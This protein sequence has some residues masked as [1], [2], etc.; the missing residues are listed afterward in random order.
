[1]TNVDFNGATFYL[2]DTGDEVYTSRGTHL[3]TL[4]STAKSKYFGADHIK[5]LFPGVEIE[6]GAT[7]LPWLADYVDT[8][9][10]VTIWNEHKDYIRHGANTSSGYR[11][12]DMLIINPDGTLHVD[13][14]VIWDYKAEEQFIHNWAG[15]K[16][17]A[18]SDGSPSWF[19]AK[20]VSHD[21]ISSIKIIEA[22]D[23]PITI[24]N[25]FFERKVCRTVAATGYE[26][27]Y[28]AYGRGIAIKRCNSTIKNLTHHNLDEPEFHAIS[29][30]AG[31][32]GTAT[33]K[34]YYG[35]NTS[36]G[37]NGYYT[38][39]KGSRYFIDQSYP[40]GGFL[41]FS[42]TYNSRA[43]DCN[44]SGRT[45]Y[46]EAKTTSSTPIPMGSYDL[47]ISGSTHVYI[48]N[49]QQLNNINDTH[50]WGIMNSNRAKNL[51]F[52]NSSLSRFDA[53][54]GFWNGTFINTTFGRYINVIG[55]GYLKIDG[56]TR[57]VG[58][59]FISLR[60][61]YGATFNGTIEIKDCTMRGLKEFRRTMNAKP[62]YESGE[63]YIINSGYSTTYD[64]A[65][66]TND[67]NSFPY[68][69]WNFGY[70]CYMPQHVIIDNFKVAG[71]PSI[72]GSYGSY[73]GINGYYFGKQKEPSASLYVFDDMGDAAF[74]K[75]SS[76]VQSDDY[77]YSC[78]LNGTTYSGTQ[79]VLLPNGTYRDMTASDVYYNQYQLTKRIDFKNM[80]KTIPICKNSGLYM[81]SNIPVYNNASYV[82]TFDFVTGE[83]K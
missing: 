16:F 38:D 83:L 28:H 12:Q 25:G 5:Q 23:E 68:L 35:V 52:I 44:L 42:E 61:D 4:T 74:V 56:C 73:T 63:L 33:W 77:T 10:F 36:K 19:G 15:T 60:G 81:Y 14:P 54:E 32:A 37:D 18:N 6:K 26:N 2:D 53:H 72:T 49:V 22:D 30:S 1:M 55:G 41:A 82:P 24:E 9:S 39:S 43:V 8:V 62:Y 67:A 48:E 64:G 76:F 51:F 59:D 78:T 34:D 75:P 27:V 79:Q 57:N 7:S 20:I 71:D 46:Y 69:K 50:Y 3:F 40:Y 66:K 11:R 65:Y 21:A 45:V 80:S 31:S 29:N 58:R 17:K 47:T 13:T 70:T